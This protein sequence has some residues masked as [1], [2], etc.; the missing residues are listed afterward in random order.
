MSHG[1][2]QEF[3]RARSAWSYFSGRSRHQSNSF[4]TTAIRANHLFRGYFVSGAR[5]GRV[6]WPPFV[7]LFVKRTT[8]HLSYFSYFFYCSMRVGP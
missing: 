7:E 3:D 4:F 1:R 6:P 5:L 8:F 2:W